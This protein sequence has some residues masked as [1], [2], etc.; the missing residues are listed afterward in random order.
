MSQLQKQQE[1]NFSSIF[2]NSLIPIWI[3]NI[4]PL[5]EQFSTMKKAGIKD[6]RAYLNES[7]QEVARLAATIEVQHV[8]D[9]AVALFGAQNRDEFLGK[10]DKMMS[11]MDAKKFTDALV[12]FWDQDEVLNLEALHRSLDNHPISVLI[13]ARIPRF[14]CDELRIPV[15]VIDVTALRENQKTLMATLEEIKKLKN[16]LPIC[17][18]CKGIRS[19]EKYW[20]QVEQYLSEHPETATTHGTCPDC[21]E[22]LGS[23]CKNNQR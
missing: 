13:S 18:T 23:H 11:L 12:S 7:P 6:L 15:T 8:N 3:E 4:A 2:Q 22:W 14:N 21:S 19:D 17:A 10:L 9:A 5:Y 1:Y 20:S 16:L